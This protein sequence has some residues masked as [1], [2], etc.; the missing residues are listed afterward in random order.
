M[1]PRAVP[2]WILGIDTAKVTEMPMQAMR[3][4]LQHQEVVLTGLLLDGAREAEF[5]RHVKTHRL[6]HRA[7]VMDRHS[8][9]LKQ[10]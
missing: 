8:A 7:Q 10:V 1:A 3:L 2:K 9:G 4:F 5:E 6:A